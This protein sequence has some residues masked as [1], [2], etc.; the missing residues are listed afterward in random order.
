MDAEAARA[1]TIAA[2]GEFALI[3]RLAQ[4]LAEV[5][6]AHAP[7]GT[8]VGIGDDAA[9]W[10]PVAGARGV[11]STDSLMAGVHFRLDWTSWRDL[12][13]KALAVNLSDIAAMGARPRL[14]VI[15]LG[16]TGAEPVADL[17]DL[18]RGVGT[19]AARYGVIVAGGDIVSSPDR[20]G[21]HLTVV[22]ESWPNLGGRLLSRTGS[23]PGDLLAVSGPLGLAAGGL[24]LLLARDSDT[25]APDDATMLEPGNGAAAL[26]AAHFRPE[27]R[28]AYGR[29][30]IEA[31]ASACIDLSDGL[32]GDL[33]KLC[34]RSDVAARV[35]R[36]SLPVPPPLRHRFPNDWLDLAT[37]GGEDYEL[38]FTLNPPALDRLR[39]YC[40][41]AQLPAPVVIGAIG[42]PQQPALVL[43]YRDG[44]E[45]AVQGGAFDHF[46]S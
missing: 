39:V 32:F 34:A 2:L 9:I 13:H 26:L 44:T 28:I 37:R 23:Q 43:R 33:A 45:L 35:D 41:A 22:G 31:G 1:T 3:E 14:A 15:A 7:D 29:A 5:G 8:I 19:L 46:A 11:I 42:P 24:R 4:V 10:Q 38:L 18:Y 20:L 36:D 17:L 40:H 30:L 12:G 27:P 16:L 25:T 6:A 21:L